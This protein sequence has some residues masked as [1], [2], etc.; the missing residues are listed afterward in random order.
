MKYSQWANWTHVG[1]LAGGILLLTWITQGQGR[2]WAAL[3]AG[4]GNPFHLPTLYM[5]RHKW[6]SKL[7]GFPQLPQAIAVVVPHVM[8][9]SY[10][11]SKTW[12][13]RLIE[14]SLWF[15][16]SLIIN[17]SPSK[18]LEIHLKN[19]YDTSFKISALVLWEGLEYKLADHS[20]SL[21]RHADWGEAPWMTLTTSLCLSWTCLSK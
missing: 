4:G 8:I 13:N 15:P 11:L 3:N 18:M 5:T 20:D 9:Y 7:P 12:H 21:E 16:T 10:L 2:R 19:R 14:L 17:D 6:F 1:S